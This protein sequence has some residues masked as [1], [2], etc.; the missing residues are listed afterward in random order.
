MLGARHTRE[1]TA[2]RGLRNRIGSGHLALVALAAL[3]V[4]C[5][6]KDERPGLW[7]SGELGAGPVRDWSFSD[8]IEEISVETRTWYGIPHSVTI[9]GATQGGRFYLPSLYYYDEEFPNARF[10]N[11]NV[12]RDPRVRVKIGDRLFDGTA[13]LVSDEGEWNRAAEAFRRKYPAFEEYAREP[14]AKWI[15]LRFELGS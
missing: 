14:G 12:V 2:V 11:R 3:T 8:A 4:G 10:W 15:F 13:E 5:Q 9:W 6:P 7:L 1:E